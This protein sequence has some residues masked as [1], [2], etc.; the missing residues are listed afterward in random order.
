MVRIALAVSL[1]WMLD[2]YST[3]PPPSVYYYKHGPWLL[4]P[5]TPS[6]A[7]RHALTIVAWGST[8]AL[9]V[10]LWSRI[11]HAVSLVTC[12]A[13]A[14]YGVSDLATWSH[15]DVPPLLA[16]IAF[17][18]AS[19][20]GALSIDRWWARWRGREPAA[21]TQTGIRLVQLAVAGVFAS[22]ALAKIRAGDWSLDWALSD[23]LRH[24][25]LAR[26]D[27]VGIPRTPTASWLLVS[28]TRYEGA[29]LLNLVSQLTPIAT[30]FLFRFP[31]LRA[32]AGACFVAEVL[33]L[34]YVMDLWNLHWLP[35]AAVFV[36]WDALASRLPG[37]RA[38]PRD[39]P[40][41][42]AERHLGRTWW[43]TSFAAC[44]LLNAL[45]LNQ[46]LNAFPFSGFPMF[47]QVRAKQPYATHQTYE[48]PGG[49][50][51]V[52]G[53]RATTAEEQSWI[54]S[55]GRFRWFWRLRDRGAVERA[56]TGLLAE[57]RENFPALEITRVR[58]SYARYQAPAY[59]APARLDRTDL[60]IIAEVSDAGVTTELGAPLTSSLMALPDLARPAV[61]FGF[62]YP[63]SRAV[64]VTRSRPGE[65]PWVVR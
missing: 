48:M 43:A 17:V 6:P 9:L 29:A 36:D 61:P 30:L 40:T 8:L 10:G 59:P 16:S 62:V 38:G 31:K 1:L 56:M 55:N 5:G 47:A 11:S 53:V 65:L 35:L 33:G 34:G 54:D 25:L 24:H 7:L 23:S 58:L 19:G 3:P 41:A 15:T 18:G 2:R 50:I 60:A 45:W 27:W 22:A 51:E 63:A 57:L 46:R 37:L 4:F 13:I 64:I 20:G 52:L 42:R 32:L 28:S 14:A 39:A 49:H 12:T 21:S 26:F 44:F